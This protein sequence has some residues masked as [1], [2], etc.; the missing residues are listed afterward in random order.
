MT[1]SIRPLKTIESRPI[2]T[3]YLCP[4]TGAIAPDREWASKNWGRLAPFNSDTY[5]VYLSFYHH[6]VVCGRIR[7]EMLARTLREVRNDYSFTE[8]I[9]ISI[10]VKGL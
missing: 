5:L 9:K 7:Y 8:I 3:S 4:F 6:A 1:K 10:E 2:I